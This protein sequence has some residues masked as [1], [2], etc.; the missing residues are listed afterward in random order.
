MCPSNNL[1][2]LHRP[3]QEV[4]DY[5]AAILPDPSL[6][7]QR[8]G[9]AVEQLSPSALISSNLFGDMQTTPSRK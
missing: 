5:L 3:T 9:I 7:N 2:K 1:E 6:E 8:L 4:V